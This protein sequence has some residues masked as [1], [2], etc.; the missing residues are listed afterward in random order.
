MRLQSLTSLF[1]IALVAV[2]A[3]APVLAQKPGAKPAEPAPPGTVPAQVLAPL[4][5]TAKALA[6]GGR[7]REMK[8]LLFALDKLGMAKA[9]HEKLEKTCKDELA[10]TKKVVDALPDGAKALRTAA[11]QIM[12]IVTAMPEG[13]DKLLLAR[14]VLLLDG[15][16]AEAHA[17]LG[18]EKVGKSWVSTEFKPM[19]E[20][21][22]DIL[23]KVLEAK[24]LE[25]PIETGEVDDELIQKYCGVQATFARR[26]RIEL[27]SNFNKAKTERI[28]REV[29]RAWSLS[30]WLRRL[31]AKPDLEL[32]LD[33]KTT[34]SRNVWILVDSREKYLKLANELMANGKMNPDDKQMFGRPNTEVGGFNTVDGQYVK[35]AQF[36]TDV[37]ASLLVALCN[38]R[39]GILSPVTAG[40]L[41]WLALSCFGCTLPNYFYKEDQGAGFGDTHVETEDQKREREELLRMA[42]AGIAGSRTWMQYLAERGED[43]AWAKSF[44]EAIGA[45]T[46][47]DLHKCTSIVEF[48]QEA[49]ILRGAYKQLSS[50]ATGRT[51]ELYNAA[52]GMTVGDLEAKWKDWLLGVRPG[53]A[54]RIDKENLNAWPKEALEVL[55]YMNDIREKAFKDKIQGLWKLK[56][57]PE[58]SEQ[59][60]LHAHYLTLHPEQKKW[61]DAHE[62][63][64]DKEGYT[65]EGAWAGAHSVIVWR[66]GG[67]EAM[68][69]EEGI[70]VW[71]GS[72]YHRLPL[73][74]PGVMRLGWG[75][76]G[77]YQVM[78]MSSLAAPYDKPFTVVFPYEGQTGVPTQFLGDE[79]PDPIPNGP[80]GSVNEADL[81][82][83][84]ITIQTN[85]SDERGDVVDI[86]M[87][88]FEG[89]DGKKEVECFFSTPSNPT[90]PEIAP[91]GAWCLIPKTFL[92]PKTT[93]KVVADWISGGRTSQTSAGKHLEWTF[94][95]N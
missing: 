12:A 16:N 76:E 71:L 6:K 31:P 30:S 93:Y 3:F 34:T 62:E 18:H 89:K 29:L 66:E 88:L 1:P 57:D 47:N 5:G 90:N 17:L 72:F 43:P 32:F 61:P 41:N 22:G 33:E 9:N 82:G 20:R 75:S 53:V 28:L 55:A 69:F 48:L 8:D 77:I 13:D 14:R 91:A 26:G 56:F 58:L 79:H 7:E 80:P 19:R 65:T 45:I 42:K 83:Y 2:L 46:G 74:D 44:V 15:E 10:K 78:D 52:L 92:K 40:H 39:E 67:E 38:M 37:Q 54:E 68:T 87:K 23:T 94:T 63:Y 70:D 49:E 95:T 11:K 73:T 36:E 50:N 4:E 59:C 85:P 64:A 86:S 60:A 84:P 81:Y 35:L 24:K 25:V 51:I 21:R 27:R